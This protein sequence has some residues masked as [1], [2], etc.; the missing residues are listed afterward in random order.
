MLENSMVIGRYYPDHARPERDPDEAYDRMKQWE[1]DEECTVK[2]E[3]QSVTDYAIIKEA[4]N[5]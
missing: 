2:K 5:G 3:V 4:H 1:L